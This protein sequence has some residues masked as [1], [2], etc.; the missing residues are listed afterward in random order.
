MA[1]R[2]ASSFDDKRARIAALAEAPKANAAAELRRFLGDKNGYLCGE[3]ARVVEELTLRELTPDLAASFLRLCEGGADVDKACLGKKRIL[4]TLLAFDADVPEVYLRG[5]RYIQMEPAF[6]RA[7]DTAAPIRG[8]S[9]HALVQI[10][11]PAALHEVTP[12]L[13]DKE[14]IVRSEAA[15]ALGRSGIEAAGAVLHLKALTGDEEPDVLQSCFEGM[16][17]L[18]PDRYLRV[19]AE[20]L[21][22]GGERSEAAAL[23]L[24]ESRHREAL[25]LLKAALDE[26]TDPRA[27]QS[28][29]MA[30]ALCR[31]DEAMATL[32]SIIEGAPEAHAIAAIGALALH[33]HD[34]ALAA[35]VRHAVAA[36]RSKKLME[37]FD[38]R[39]GPSR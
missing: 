25:P 22:S 16:L 8:L 24:G 12:L 34:D 1:A 36:R 29:L 35:R 33:R 11:H 37:A 39:F 5:I 13:V 20:V 18:G 26:V 4:E 17:R 30:I 21:R 32:L 28:V 23:A 6:P 2:R 27:R 15:R 14:A 38:D 9:A 31:S 7:A 19:V 10:D 3:A